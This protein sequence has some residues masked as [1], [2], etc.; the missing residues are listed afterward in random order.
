MYVVPVCFKIFHDCY[1]LSIKNESRYM[2][3]CIISIIT[4]LCKMHI[5]IH[6]RWKNSHEWHV[7]LVSLL[8]LRYRIGMIIFLLSFSNS[9]SHISTY[10]N[11]SLI[12]KVE[13]IILCS[14]HINITSICLNYQVSFKLTKKSLCVCLAIKMKDMMVY[15][16]LILSLERWHGP[17]NIM[18]SPVN[19]KHVVDCIICT[20]YFNLLYRLQ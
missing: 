11:N 5:N 6:A 17:H 13:L 3:L 8:L 16:V 18:Q 19:K 1:T 2:W 14:I 9:I 20:I 12:S 4:S 7:K 10:I 15:D